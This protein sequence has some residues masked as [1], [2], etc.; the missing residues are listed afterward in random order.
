MKRYLLTYPLVA[1]LVGNACIPPN[2]TTC[3]ADTDCPSGYHCSAQR[4]CAAVG[5]TADAAR[6]DGAGS[7]QPT[8]DGGPADRPAVD[9]SAV[10]TFAADTAIVDGPRPD[11]PAP[12]VAAGDGGRPDTAAANDA[13]VADG[14]R[15]C[16]WGGIECIALGT[17]RADNPCFYCGMFMNDFDWRPRNDGDS[18]GP[19]AK[20]YSLVCTCDSAHQDCN[21]NAPGCE[22]SLFDKTNCLSC[23]RYCGFDRSCDQRGCYCNDPNFDDCDDDGVCE[24]QLTERYA[25]GSGGCRDRCNPTACVNYFRCGSGQQCWGGACGNP[26]PGVDAG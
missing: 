12:D 9:A 23:G 7:D 1:V 4:M 18:C 16:S 26:C 13:A 2:T 21:P 15:G 25:C 3:Q 20:C 5:P 24:C 11:V 8:T 22:T 6:G 10:D 17:P 19:Y 14:C